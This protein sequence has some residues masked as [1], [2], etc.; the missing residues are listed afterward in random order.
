MHRAWDSDMACQVDLLARW[1][2]LSCLSHASEP[3]RIP[4]QEVDGWGAEFTLS[5]QPSAV[6]HETRRIPTLFHKV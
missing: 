3:G 2:Y 1:E 5:D 6:F 4:L